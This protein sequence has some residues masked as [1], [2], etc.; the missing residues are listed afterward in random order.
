M[1]TPVEPEM[2]VIDV[3]L[4]V[5]PKSSATTCRLT[6]PTRVS[7]LPEASVVAYTPDAT[8]VKFPA[9][10]ALRLRLTEHAVPPVAQGFVPL[11]VAVSPVV[12]ATVKATESVP[13]PGKPF[14]A[15]AVTVAVF[16]V[17]GNSGPKLVGVAVTVTNGIEATA[18]LS[19]VLP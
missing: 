15:V 12:D 3:G 17:P 7:G 9:A 2:K 13:K 14:I 4:I 16:A 1:A 18:E 5:K 19:N 8:A 6:T 11:R 10:V